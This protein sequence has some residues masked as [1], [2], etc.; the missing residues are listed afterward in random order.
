VTFLSR[1][2]DET[3]RTFRVEVEVPN[4][5]LAIRAGQT[6][7]I[8]VASDGRQAFM[9]VTLLRDTV[10]GVWV[11]DLPDTVNI[12]TVGQEFV[13]DGVPVAPTYREVEG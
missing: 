8:V 1:S 13:I 10:D 2:A 9:P 7:E 4:A 5:D 12:I 11:A 6:V 3:T